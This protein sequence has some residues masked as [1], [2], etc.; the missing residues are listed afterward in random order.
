M[1]YTL[2]TEYS[3]GDNIGIII[4]LGTNDT[5]GISVLNETNDGIFPKESADDIIGFIR[6]C[7]II[8]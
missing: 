4:S 2:G 3:K 1:E 6:W 7:G 5:L 8:I